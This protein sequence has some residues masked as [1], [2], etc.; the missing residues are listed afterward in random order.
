MKN[1]FK[2]I[3]FIFSFAFLPDFT[4]VSYGQKKVKNCQFPSTV[5]TDIQQKI[6][7]Q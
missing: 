1:I 3:A 7:D 5:H 6:L 4:N 2:I